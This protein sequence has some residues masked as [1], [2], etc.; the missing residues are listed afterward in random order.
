VPVTY[1]FWDLHVAIQD[2]M[3]WKDCHLHEFEL[4]NPTTGE[5]V[6]LGIPDDEVLDERPTL[7]GWHVPAASYLH[8]E[9]A[10]LKYL[11]DFGD[12]WE[13]E[14]TFEGV[15]PAEP[16]VRYPRCLDGARACPPE[17]VGGPWG[18]EEF[19]ESIVDPEHE[20]HE[21]MLRWVGG[22]FDAEA[23]TAGQVRFD[24]P[25]RRWKLAFVRT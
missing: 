23:F 1:T 13:H 9:G 24:D 22:Q 16:R 12:S 14:V 2:A 21:D 8:A 15:Y 19:V 6:R 5:S 20:Q 4:V 10:R 17:D 3:G 7:P 11:Y 18:Y 25:R